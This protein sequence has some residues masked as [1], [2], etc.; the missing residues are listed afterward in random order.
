MN[1]KNNFDFM[2]LVAATLVVYSH[3]F[4]LL[5]VYGQEPFLH[6]AG[7]FAGGDLGV[8]I[9][10]VMSGYLVAA[11]QQ[12]SS[13]TLQFLSKRAL[14]IFPALTVVV[15]LSIFVLG[16]ML[17]TLPLGDYF[18]HSATRG[19]LWNIGL[20]I[21]YPLPGVFTDLPHAG[22]V[23]GSLWTLPIEATMYAGIAVL[24]ATSLLRQRWLP[25]LVVLLVGLYVYIQQHPEMKQL[26]L[27]K[28]GPLKDIVRLAVFFFCGAS[29][30]LFDRRMR[31]HP[32]IALVLSIAWIVS[33]RTPLGIYCMF[34]AVPY[35]TLYIARGAY[36]VVA[37]FGRH[38]DFSYG[39]YIYAFPIQQ[40][41]VQLLGTALSPLQ[42]F[43][44]AVPLALA[45]AFL[46][47]HLVEKP[48][49]ALKSRLMARTTG[50]ATATAPQ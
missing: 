10:F 30:Y 36:A 3:S 37:D 26:T 41:L 7:H 6:A 14:R 16:P 40:T 47:W 9:F 31:W 28:I 25:I 46:S 29:L 49:L 44:M 5:G 4:P 12:N 8:A 1:R 27:W 22:S 20:W 11:S 17:T 33:F 48:A 43:L 15:A 42:L 2:R 35:C 24:G 13:S 38:G 45:C 23:N 39:I 21:H 50:T 32:G 18:R 34:A 19:Y